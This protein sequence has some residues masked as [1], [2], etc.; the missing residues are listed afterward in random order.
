MASYLCDNCIPWQV[1]E[2]LVLVEVQACQVKDIRELGTDATEQQIAEWCERREAVW[3][4]V[5]WKARKRR[6]VQAIPALARISIAFFRP[7]SRSGWTRRQ[8]VQQV[9]KRIDAMEKQF[10]AKYPV[11]YRFS[12]R[13]AREILRM[14]QP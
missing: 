9:L 11:W 7:P 14:P 4:T 1:A 6:E 2:V 5:D 8:F 10:G 3:M 12:A 13:G